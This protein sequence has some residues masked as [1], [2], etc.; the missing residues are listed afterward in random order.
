[1]PVKVYYYSCFP[2]MQ[3]NKKL[4]F[5]LESSMFP[6]GGAM[7]MVLAGAAMTMN[8]YNDYC[9]C[10]ILR[11]K[12]K[13]QAILQVKLCHSFLLCNMLTG[14]FVMKTA[15]KIPKHLCNLVKC[16]CLKKTHIC[17]K[18]KYQKK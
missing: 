5:R 18:F 9:R 6:V 14:C 11:H 17:I 15:F 13:L 16:I 8:H 1:M 2:I 12:F 3:K 4:E 10:L 7:T